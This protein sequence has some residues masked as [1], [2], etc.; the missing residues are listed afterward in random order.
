MTTTSTP[1]TAQ[2]GDEIPTFER[3]ADFPAW[4]RYA[5]VNDEFVPIHMDDDAGRNAGMSSA[6]GMGNLGVSH[7]H[8]ML[9]DWLDGQGR[10]TGVAI[11]F[12]S[13]S[14]RSRTNTTHGKVVDV[15]PAD[16]SGDGRRRLGLEVWIDD[17]D[18]TVLTRG[19]AT[20]EV[21][22]P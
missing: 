12:R 17:G 13:P 22:A 9:R 8:C 18:G 20:V 2:V 15:S 21:D 3:F 4:N 14:L 11:Q 7:I 10:I 16:V 5:A 19:T 6:I 1:R